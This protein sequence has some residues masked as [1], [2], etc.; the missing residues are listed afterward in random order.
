MR[1]IR[2]TAAAE[3]DIIEILEHSERE[4]GP[5]ARERYDRL[6]RSALRDLAESPTRPGSAAR[7]ELGDDI[8]SWHLRLSRERAKVDGLAVRRPRHL[9]LYA[10]IG[11]DVV[12]ILRVLHDAME[13]HRH[14]DPAITFPPSD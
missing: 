1:T 13:L 4:F 6:M 11:D 2:L 14:I 3:A 8:R 5:A 9:L 12:G 10:L 7:R